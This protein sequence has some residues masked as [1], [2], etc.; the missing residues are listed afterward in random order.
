MKLNV[1]I[2]I[3]IILTTG[4]TKQEMVKDP[5]KTEPKTELVSTGWND[6]DTY[7]VKVVSESVDRGKEKAKHQILQDIVKVRMLNES[8]FTDI[9]KINAEFEKP[10]KN[11]KVISEKKVE[12]G[13]EIYFQIKDEGL[14]QKFEKK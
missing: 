12:N 7:T 2:L 13:V 14:K 8:R 10:L 1:F 3:F 4:C 11:G 9:T 6:A 5:V